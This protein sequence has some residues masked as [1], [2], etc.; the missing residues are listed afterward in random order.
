MRFFFCAR[1]ALCALC[2]LPIMLMLVLQGCGVNPVT[3]KRELQIYG[4]DWERSIGA[5]QYQPTQQS[6]G[7][8]L[9]GYPELTQ[10]VKQVG[11]RV[12]EVSHRPELPYDFVVLDS[13]VPNAWAL[14]G[15][16]VAINWG[17]LTELQDEAELAAVLGHEV[18]HATARHGAQQM[19]RGILTSVAVVGL[20]VGL[21]QS[22][23]DK[24]TR[25]AVVGAA[26]VGTNLV[27]TKYGRNAELE[28]DRYGI[29]YMVKAGYDPQAAVRLQQTF[30]RLKDGKQSNWLEGLF[31]THPPSEERVAAN[32]RLANQ[33]SPPSGVQWRTGKRDYQRQIKP[34]LALKKS[35]GKVDE[36]YKALKKKRTQDALTLAN[37]ALSIDPRN[38]EANALMAAA[39][40][41][42]GDEARAEASMSKAIKKK[43]GFYRYYEDRAQIRMKQGDTSGARADLERSTRLLPT[44]NAHFAL[45]QLAMNAGDSRAA[46]S[47]FKLASQDKSKLGQRASAN[48][49]KLDLPQNPGRYVNIQKL[50]TRDGE[51]VLRITNN[52]DATIQSATLLIQPPSGRTFTVPLN[53]AIKA[54]SSL[55]LRTGVGPLSQEAAGS[56]ALSMRQIQVGG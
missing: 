56:T 3:G 25:S 49:A 17:L 26:A 33:Y 42:E 4:E 54:R 10:Y 48:I 29:E 16:K 52:S 44:A 39:Y 20:Q 8:R 7:G 53:Q 12:A 18:T 14:P 32:Q 13:D 24:T 15:G 35:A 22:E 34:L 45:G 5:Q 31:S 30:V 28:A 1:R 19:E 41:Q 2:A 40:Y 51:L 9:E 46:I 37:Q 38:A 47:H 27:L 11:Q 36:G 55:D 23:L 50:L 21:S 43:D 6:G